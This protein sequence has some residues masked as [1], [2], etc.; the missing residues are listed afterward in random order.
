MDLDRIETFLV[1]AEELHFG[2]ASE[3]LHVSQPMVSRRL[4]AF[5]RQI[6]GALFERTSRRVRLTPLGEELRFKLAP[7]HRQLASAIG[8]ARTIATGV[9]GELRLGCVAT[10][11][12]EPLTALLEAFGTQDPECRMTLREHLITGEAWDIFGPLRRG[13]SDTLFYFNGIHEPDLTA[14]PVIELFDRV[15]LV[16]R[17]HRFATRTAVSVEE[18]VTERLA[19]R[20]PSLPASIMELMNPSHT[21][22]GQPIPHTEP[23][24]SVQEYMSLIARGRIVAATVSG[25]HLARRDDIVAVPLEGLPPV[26]LGLI[27]CTA[28]ENA[29]IRA[30]AKVA[31]SLRPPQQRGTPLNRHHPRAEEAARP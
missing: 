18:L 30:L 29:R 11:P 24:K 28:H 7:A 20:P 8:H 22:S 27:W 4:T 15:L 9:T 10:A 13:E 31:K 2:R 19:A 23:V 17:T 1:L 12:S 25:N 21:P 14:G 16:G 5:E 6:G 26:P 3:R